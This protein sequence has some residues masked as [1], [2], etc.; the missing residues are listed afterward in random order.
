MSSI[1]DVITRGCEAFDQYRWEEAYTFLS[2]AQSESPLGPRE[3]ER[4]AMSAHLTGRDTESL[5]LL[6]RTHHASLA[7]GDIPR[8]ARCAFWLA[9]VAMAAN[10]LARS[11]G[12]M[13]RARRVLDENGCETVERGYLLVLDGRRSMAEGNPVKALELFEESASLGERF[14]DSD[15][16]ALARQACGRAL[17]RLGDAKKGGALLDEVMVAVTAGELSPIVAGVVYCSVISACFDIR[18]SPRPRMDR[19]AQ[20][21]VFD[22]AGTRAIS[23]RVSRA[24]RRNPETARRVAGCDLGSTARVRPSVGTVESTGNGRRVLPTG[25]ARTP[26]RSVRRRRTG[27][28]A[29]E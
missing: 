3:L 2:S 9:T 23:W 15:L 4:L 18:C 16:V 5:E 11:G 17:I 20:S 28:P 12:W 29:S 24:S 1:H 19:S 21:V 13:A 10:D 27:V 26:A 22:T 6:T 14:G 7:Q 8:A 25:G